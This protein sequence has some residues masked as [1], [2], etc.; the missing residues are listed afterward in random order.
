[1]IANAVGVVL[2]SIGWVDHDAIWRFDTGRSTVDTIPLETGAQYAALHAGSA[3][4]FAVTHHFDGRR[5]EIS[6]R[7]FASPDRAVARAVLDRQENTFDGDASAWNH[8]PR[9]YIA[10]LAEPWREFALLVISPASGRIDVQRFEWFDDSY[11]KDYQGVLDVVELT[12]RG[13]AIVSVQRSSRL[14]LHDLGNGGAAQTI[15]LAGR[16]GNPRLRLRGE[17]L[18]AT[19]YDTLVVVSTRD[20]RVDRRRRLQGAGTGTRE[21]VGDFAFMPDGALCAVARPFSGDVVAVDPG[22]LRIIASA[23]LGRQPLEV[24]ALAGGEIVARDWKTGEL[25]RGP[26]KR[27]RFP[28]FG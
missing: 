22:T 28:W 27:R 23:K 18:W 26:L 13:T 16:A 1:M 11:D 20:W 4:Y 8:V 2:S 15:D 21:F 3:D 9:L 19:D 24:A 14:I 25:L 12:G 10:Y 7:S 17:E 6:V 5:F